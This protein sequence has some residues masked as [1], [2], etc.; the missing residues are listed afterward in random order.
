MMER[1]PALE[2]H[3]TA[4]IVA[5]FDGRAKAAHDA[6][7]GTTSEHLMGHWELW[8]GDRQLF[9]GSRAAAFQ[10]SFMDHLI[11]H[12]AQLGVYLRLNDVAIPGSYGPSADEP[13]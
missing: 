13:W 1:T 9:T 5:A 2:V 12:R 11:H 4:D 8:F 10:S 6:L 3:S 7:A